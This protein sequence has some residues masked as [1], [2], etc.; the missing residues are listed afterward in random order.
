MR[1]PSVPLPDLTWGRV[2]WVTQAFH[3]SVHVT[4]NHRSACHT[5]PLSAHHTEPLSARHTEPQKCLSHRT[6]QCT[7]HRTTEVHVTQNHRS[8]VQSL[9]HVPLFVTSW[10]AAHQ[11]SLSITNSQ[12]LLKLTSIESV[13]PSDPLSFPSP[14]TFNLS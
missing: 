9:S 11:A 4:Q 5:E 13:I 1:R 6:T 12:S 14:P 10:T 3:H 7:S 2:H 8:S